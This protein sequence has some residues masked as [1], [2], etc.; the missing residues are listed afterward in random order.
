MHEKQS[1]NPGPGNYA[2]EKTKVV[3]GVEDKMNNTFTTK[4]ILAL[5]YLSRFYRS[6]DFVQ[7][8]QALVFSN[9]QPTLIT[10]D[11]VYTT[12]LKTGLKKPTWIK[13]EA[14]TDQKLTKT[15]SLISKEEPLQ[16][17]PKR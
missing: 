1:E 6:Q 14:N 13:L 8:L 3:V 9:L 15:L 5:F 12:I 4:V 7:L 10:Q 11:Q 2:N 17:Q 16:F